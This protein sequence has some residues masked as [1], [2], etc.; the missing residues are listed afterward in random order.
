MT[1]STDDAQ[2]PVVA[3]MAERQRFESWL[4]AL[5]ERRAETPERVFERVYADYSERLASVVRELG[6]HRDGLERS[7]SEHLTRGHELEER[8]TRCQDERAEAELRA[9]VGEYTSERWDEVRQ[10]SDATLER[11]AGE[12]EQNAIELVRLREALAATVP[13]EVGDA[14][15]FADTEEAAEADAG[16]EPAG[17]EEHAEEPQPSM[18]ADERDDEDVP[19]AGQPAGGQ[20]SGSGA[21]MPDLKAPRHAPPPA[22][23]RFDE[24]AFLSSVVQAPTPP[25]APA[26]RETGAIPLVDRSSAA[27]KPP[28]PAPR[29]SAPQA[30]SPQAQSP[31]AQAPQAQAP[32]AQA[33]QA[34]APRPAAPPRPPSD[35]QI[36]HDAPAPFELDRL[37]AS[38]PGGEATKS[39]RC[40]E[41]GTMNYP[42]EWYCE[43][44]GGELAAL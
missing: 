9:A 23:S 32:Q 24:L 12:Q 6:E 4:Q 43:R 17:D 39:L 38:S 7:I 21:F 22:D 28:A 11:L 1:V 33:P 42:T 16:V 41:C 8:R 13:A 36:E 5:E 20:A 15:D 27:D 25:P 35:L 18:N 30:Q 34:Q 19:I 31:Q 44:C 26:R 14:G 40:S 29:A 37:P 3:L 10:E 2:D